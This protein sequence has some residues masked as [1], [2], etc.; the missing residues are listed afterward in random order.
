MPP[1]RTSGKSIEGD[2]ERLILTRSDNSNAYV[3]LRAAVTQLDCKQRT[4]L[5][6][7]LS[8]TVIQ[9]EATWFTEAYYF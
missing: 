7:N 8:P 4:E 9:S 2:Y 5:H 1:P 6:D 3:V